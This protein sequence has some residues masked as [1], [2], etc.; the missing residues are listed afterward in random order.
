MSIE[1]H[2]RNVGLLAVCQAL[3]S[4]GQ[5]MLIIL[6]GLVGATLADNPALATLPVSTVVIGT[7][8]ATIPASLLMKR[9]GRRAGFLTGTAVGLTGASVAAVAIF[10]RDFVLFALGTFLW[11]INTGFAQF[12]RFAATD[13]A[14]PAFRGKAIS[15][16]L[17]GGVAAAIAGPTLVR[18]TADLL[19]PIPFL[20]AYVT[21]TVLPLLAA[22]ALAFLD[23]PKPGTAESAAPGRPLLAIVRQPTFIVAVLGGMVGYSVMNL[24]MTATPLAMVGCGFGVADAALVIQ[25]H[26]IAMFAPSFVTG[27]IIQRFG[28]LNVMLAGMVLLAACVAVALA[29]VDIGHFAV[30]LIALGLGWNFAFV[31]A[32]TLVTE[33]YRPAE[34]AKA[35]ATNDFLVFGSVACASLSSGAVLH[36]FGWDA[37]Q[38]FA[39]P[40]V[41]VAAAAILWLKRLRR[42]AAANS[43]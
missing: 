22:L 41:A 9:I 6:S 19:A 11:G 26:V 4:T 8:S 25:W 33:A 3:S 18:V 7:L 5:S 36:L 40:F 16:V 34:R 2:H 42:R 14:P 28:V 32:S 27:V 31:G 43:A 38:V 12:Y 29:G 15:L 13:V 23:I 1:R 30:A 10:H 17:A 39:L 35:Q 21:L 37:V 20:G 24:V